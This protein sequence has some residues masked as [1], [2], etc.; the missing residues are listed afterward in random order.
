MD[1]R[2]PM[3]PEKAAEDKRAARELVTSGGD[4]RAAYRLLSQAVEVA[5]D[6]ESL[7]MMAEIEV[8]NPLWRQRALD[9]FKQALEIEPRMTSAWLGL[10]NYWSLRGQP[11]K[12]CRCLEK[13]LVY[14]PRND[15]VRRALDLLR[16]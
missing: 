12:Q 7:A 14:D 15:E 6:A 9:H 8:A 16:K 2:E 5:P 1:E 11:D 10:G 4:K 13:I 3:S